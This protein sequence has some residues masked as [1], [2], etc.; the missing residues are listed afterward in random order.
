MKIHLKAQAFW[1]PPRESPQDFL[2][3]EPGPK[4]EG[5]VVQPYEAFQ[6]IFG[7]AVIPG[8]G[9]VPFKDAAGDKFTDENKAS[10]DAAPHK[11]I[12]PF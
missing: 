10:V 3:K 11:G 8:A 12:L 4:P 5:G 6:V 7:L 1:Q 9:L 2:K